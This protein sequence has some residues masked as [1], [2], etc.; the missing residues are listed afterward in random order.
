MPF[1]QLED[2]D[3]RAFRSAISFQAHDEPHHSWHHLFFLTILTDIRMLTTSAIQYLELPIKEMR[4]PVGACER[5][6]HDASRTTNAIRAKGVI[7]KSQISQAL[8]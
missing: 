1:L 6:V 3:S 8:K 4:K 2:S 5:N 7:I